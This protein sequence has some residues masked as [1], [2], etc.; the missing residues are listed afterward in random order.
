MSLTLFDG[1]ETII[2][3]ESLE[4]VDEYSWSNVKQDVKATIGGGLVISESVVSAGRPITLIGGE[5][6]WIDKTT[7]DA[8]MLLV[9]IVGKV[10]TLTMPDGRTFQVVFNRESQAVIAKPVFR[11]I[12]QSADA[13]YTITLNLMEV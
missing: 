1:T 13:K 4:W 5:S 9:N 12:T 7:L 6:V 3:P 11:Q 2:L 10:Y 8:L